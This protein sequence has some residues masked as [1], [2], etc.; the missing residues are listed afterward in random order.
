[1]HTR[2]KWRASLRP[3]IAAARAWLAAQPDQDIAH[4]AGLT[5]CRDHFE[6][7]FLQRTIHLS[8][9]GFVAQTVDGVVCAEEEQILLLDYI[10]R[11]RGDLPSGRFVGFRELPDGPFY[12]RAFRSYTSEALVR[13][14]GDHEDALRRAAVRLGGTA[15]EKGSAAYSFHVLP[16]LVVAIVWWSGDEEFP[17]TATVLYDEVT[18]HV[19][20][21]DGLAAIGRILC[22]ELLRGETGGDE[23]RHAAQGNA[24]NE[25]SPKESDGQKGATNVEDHCRSRNPGSL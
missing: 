14:F 4:R 5:V 18:S 20:P 11:A 16:R 22:A 6:L 19:L 9:A 10:S 25:C 23:S 2:D 12:D 3:R 1:M 7:S 17:A 24:R 8:R 15:I 13:G 21:L